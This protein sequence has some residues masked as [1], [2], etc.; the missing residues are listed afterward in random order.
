MVHVNKTDWAE[1]RLK[2]LKQLHYKQ[3][4][5][6]NKIGFWGWEVPGTRASYPDTGASNGFLQDF[7]DNTKHAMTIK[8]HTFISPLITL[9]QYQGMFI[10]PKG[11]GETCSQLQP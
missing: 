2:A 11:L 9:S 7:H 6:W 1:E 10:C 3:S 5:F 8:F 4:S